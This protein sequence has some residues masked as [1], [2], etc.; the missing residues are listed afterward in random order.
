MPILGQ[1]ACLPEAREK[2]KFKE[3][4]FVIADGMM[5]QASA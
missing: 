3:R 5:T 4:R 1:H 2:L